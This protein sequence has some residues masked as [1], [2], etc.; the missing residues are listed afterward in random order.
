MRVLWFC[1][2]MLPQGAE[3]LGLPKTNYGGWMAALFDSLTR[4]NPDSEFCIVSAHEKAIRKTVGKVTYVTFR[5][6]KFASF[7]EVVPREIC[8]GIKSIVEGFLPDVIHINGTESYYPLLSNDIL[9]GKPSLVSLQGIINACYPF[10]SG[11]LSYLELKPFGNPIRRALFRNGIFEAQQEWQDERARQERA[12]ISRHRYFAGRTKWDEIWLQSM[13][14]SAEYFHLDEVMRPEFY[15]T[16]RSALTVRP[17][18]IYCSAAASYPLKGFHWLLRA[19]AMILPRFPD[20]QIRVADSKVALSPHGGL[21]RMLRD[22]DYHAY[23]RSLILSLGLADNVVAL[24]ALDAACVVRELEMAELFCL[25]SL[26]ENSPNSLAEAMLQGVPSIASNVG[27][28]PSM[29]EDLHSGVLC[30]PADPAPLAAALA[31]LFEDHGLAGE[32]STNAR[33][34]AL[35]RHDP[36]KVARNVWEAYVIIAESTH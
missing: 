7:D 12:A 31:M 6:P 14:S 4:M 20:L 11:S 23:L 9:A 30:P 25:P 10:Y 17:H 24:P 18:T 5:G 2:F 22:Q 29:I 21:M 13:N 26:C 34:S 36:E 35:F 15:S 1:N 3:V 28:V 32:I 19:V 16:R 27:G 33:A 8:L